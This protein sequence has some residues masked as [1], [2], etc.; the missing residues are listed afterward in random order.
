[1][2][3]PK[4][5]FENYHLPP[6]FNG[7]PLGEALKALLGDQSWGQVRQLIRGRQVQVN[8]NLCLDEQRPVKVG[9]V[10]KVWETPLA[11]P[12]QADQ[13]RLAYLDEHV[14][15]VE[16][17][18]GLTTMR[19]R[20]ER[21]LSAQRKLLQPT[22]D[23]LL[24]AAVARELGQSSRGSKPTIRAVHRLDRDTSGL[25]VF[26]RTA[27]AEQVLVQMFKRH[28]L[29]RAYI[30]VA[31]G[32]VEQQTI[33]QWLIRDRGDG[34]RGS[35]PLG[36]EFAEAQR[37]VTHFRPMEFLPGYTILECRLETGRTHQ[38]RIALAEIGHMLCGE[39]T[40]HVHLDRTTTPDPSGAPR[41]ALHAA[42]LG[43]AHPITGAP[44]LF[45]MALPRDLATWILK[46]RKSK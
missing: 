20:E 19:H 23:E 43:F 24:P 34:R 44:L 12:I 40:Y 27:A 17:P 38:I 42:E 3:M 15:V 28:A 7:D 10:I 45:R 41:Q 8:G 26:A 36:A 35:T 31:L 16:K 14:V 39:K 30:A 33:E 22:L 9:D 6:E 2:T 13:I 29:R 4:P 25:M 1:M 11:K 18:A 46:L 5:E 32:R 37:A 21:K